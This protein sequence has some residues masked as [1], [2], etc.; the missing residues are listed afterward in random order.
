[1]LAVIGDRWDSCIIPTFIVMK[2]ATENAVKFGLEK[3]IYIG[4]RQLLIA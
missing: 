1:M 4:F 3:N 2:L